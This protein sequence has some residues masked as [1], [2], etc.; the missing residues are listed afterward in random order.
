MKKYIFT[1]AL[2]TSLLIT[3]CADNEVVENVIPDSQKEMISFSLSDGAS[4]TRAGFRGSSTFIAMRIQSDSK[5]SGET[6]K[7]TRTTATAAKDEMTGDDTYSTVSFTND[8]KRYWDDAHGRYSKLSVY[9]VAI[10]NKSTD[11]ASQSLEN[12]LKAGNESSTWGTNADN[13]IE[14]SV[15]TTAQTK[16][17]GSENP[18]AVGDGTIDN[19]DL[20]YSNNIKLEGKNG[21]YR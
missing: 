12:K 20:V 14:W 13:T 19:E 8:Q 1:T 17:S 16:D 21:I 5:K 3:S 2:A 6:T 18:Q 9:A 10:P 7:Y 11:D 15:T 4:Q